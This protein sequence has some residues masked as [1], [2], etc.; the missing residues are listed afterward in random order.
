MQSLPSE[1]RCL[2]VQ[3]V[4]LSSDSSDSPNNLVA[5]A[6]THSSYQKEAERELYKNLSIYNTSDDSLKCMETLATNS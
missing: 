3:F 2:I 5:L 1:L 6:R 4:E